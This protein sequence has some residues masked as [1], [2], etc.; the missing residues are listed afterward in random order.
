MR[1]NIGA[2]LQKRV[3]RR[4]ATREGGL[5]QWFE[6]MPPTIHCFTLEQFSAVNSQIY[7]HVSNV[8]HRCVS[9]PSSKTIALRRPVMKDGVNSASETHK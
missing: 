4:S 1:S 8:L 9:K 2:V 6:K 5:V 3:S 7:T